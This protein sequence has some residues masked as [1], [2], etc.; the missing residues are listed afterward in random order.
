MSLYED[1]I[2]HVLQQKSYSRLNAL[3][4]IKWDIKEICRYKTAF[5]TEFLKKI[6]LFLYKYLYYYVMDLFAFSWN[7][8]FKNFFSF[9]FRYSKVW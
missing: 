9:N 6:L 3:S 1:E 7:N 8:I 5:L 4:S 2:L